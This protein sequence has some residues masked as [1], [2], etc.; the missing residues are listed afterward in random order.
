MTG[1]QLVESYKAYLAAFN[2]HSFSGIKSY[3]SPDCTVDYNGRRLANSRED[4]LPTY[5]AHWEKYPSGIELQE[6]RPIESGVWVRLRNWEQGKDLEVEYLYDE[7]GLQI[8]HIIKEVK[9]FKV[10][11][12]KEE[13]DNVEV[14]K[15]KDVNAEVL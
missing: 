7:N 9:P 5:P 4:M 11:S 14:P 3:I 6:I 15:A 1:D 2:A 8:K 12:S 10:E 13:D